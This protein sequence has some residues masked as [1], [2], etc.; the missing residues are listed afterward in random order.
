MNFR[1]SA[2]AAALTIVSIPSISIAE[3]LKVSTFVPPN[4]A[5]N[6][7]LTSWGEEL[8]AKSDGALAL[9]IFPSGQLGPTPRQFDLVASGAADISVVLH[10]A[11]PGRFPVTELVAMPFT[12]PSVGDQSAATSRRLTEIAPDFLMD[13]HEGMKILW[14]AVTPPLK[15]HLSGTNPSSLE[16]FKGLRLRY[17]G[18]TWQQIFEILGASPVPVPPPATADALSKG[19]VDGASFPFE[20]T[21]SFD[22]APML[23]Y[24]LEPGIASATFAVIMSQ[25]SFDAL[26]EDMQGLINDTT[27]PDMATAFGASWDKGEA[28]SREYLV[29]A[30]VEVVSLPDDEMEALRAKLAPIRTNAIEK[31]N[32]MGLPAQAFLDAYEK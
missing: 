19:V 31:A 28:E 21:K 23:K 18:S 8:S 14:M 17:A 13:E 24:S 25:A 7:M 27:G 32:G 9:E 4:H 16:A 1:M 5:F 26:P 12:T 22:L 29:D 6:K 10:A 15:V 20:A 11:T 30:G 3:T 2:F